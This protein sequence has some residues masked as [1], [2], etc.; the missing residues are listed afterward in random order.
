MLKPG[1]ELWSLGYIMPAHSPLGYNQPCQSKADS[2][3]LGMLVQ[4]LIL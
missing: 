4:F 2:P 1:F 3:A